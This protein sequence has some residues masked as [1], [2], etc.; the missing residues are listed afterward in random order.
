MVLE[1]N[2]YNNAVYYELEP[3]PIDV[4]GHLTRTFNGDTALDAGAGSV[5]LA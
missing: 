5:L 2:F 3:K 4:T 1:S